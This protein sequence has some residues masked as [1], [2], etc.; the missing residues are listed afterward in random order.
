[1]KESNDDA[2]D[3]TVVVVVGCSVEE[4]SIVATSGEVP[5]L[6]FLL[7]LFFFSSIMTC[8]ALVQPSKC[9]EGER[10]WV[11]CLVLVRVDFVFDYYGT[12]C[13][14]GTTY[15]FVS[16]IVMGLFSFFPQFSSHEN[17]FSFFVFPATA[18]R[19]FRLRRVY[20]DVFVFAVYA[21]HWMV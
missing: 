2:A 10:E 3:V 20:Y 5:V 15:I 13:D 19:V 16:L 8:S 4:E 14:Q 6:L 7:L 18:S 9:Y 21:D 12:M 17:E 11:F 1:M